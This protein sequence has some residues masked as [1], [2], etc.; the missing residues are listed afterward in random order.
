MKNQMQ[1]DLIESDRGSL[2][3][4][5]ACLRML[6]QGAEGRELTWKEAEQLSGYREGHFTW[7]YEMFG[8]L[9]ERG[10]SV[11]SIE[12]IDPQMMAKSPS[13]VVTAL[14]GDGDLGREILEDMDAGSER[15]NAA[16]CLENPQISFE[17]R[18]PLASDVEQAVSGG[19]YVLVSLDYGVLHGTGAY[20]GHMVLVSGVAESSFVVYDPGP[21]GRGPIGVE[22]A[23]LSAAMAS[24]SPDAGAVIVVTPAVGVE[25]KS[26]TPS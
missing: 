1:I 13:E 18:P 5:Q 24:P 8:T 19:G 9:A 2:H 3:C 23:T 10:Y 11:R 20:E 12:A 15:R 14:Y 7:P 22:R 17:V 21:P 6:V 26:P 16:A 25:V 4:L